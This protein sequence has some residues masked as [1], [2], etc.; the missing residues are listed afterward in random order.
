[1]CWHVLARRHSFGAV[2][3]Y[4]SRQNGLGAVRTPLVRQPQGRC[5]Q[6]EHVFVCRQLVPVVEHVFV[7]RQ[8]V[9]RRPLELQAHRPLNQQAAESSQA[10][11]SAGHSI[12]RLTGR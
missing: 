1:M 10:A 9:A 3:M 6:K 7:R 4:E 12:C 8:P 2:T 11:E 5:I